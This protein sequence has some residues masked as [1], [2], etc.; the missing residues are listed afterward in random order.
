MQVDAVDRRI[1]ALLS[2]DAR[3]SYADIGALVGLSAPAV[4]RR[5]DRLRDGAVITRFTTV[6]DPAALGWATE[7][8]VELFCRGRTSTA[9]IA[10]DLRNHPEVVAAYSVTGEADALVHLRTESTGHLEE[11]LERIRASPITDHTRSVIV[12]SRLID[13]PPGPAPGASLD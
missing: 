1:I 3:R 5:V 2:E 8:F 13:R 12:L 11:T 7:A 4:K 9:A 6:V 10:A